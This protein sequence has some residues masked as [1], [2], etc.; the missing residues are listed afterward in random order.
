MWPTP[1]KPTAA[2][3]RRRRE[4]AAVSIVFDCSDAARRRRAV[5][6]P[7]ARCS[8]RARSRPVEVAGDTPG[9][10]VSGSVIDRERIRGR[11]RQVHAP[12]SASAAVR[13]VSP[14]DR[15]T[16]CGREDGGAAAALDAGVPASCPMTATLSGARASR[17]A[18]RV[19]HEH[20]APRRRPRGRSAAP[21]LHVQA[22]RSA[23]GLR[24]VER[25]DAVRRIAVCAGPCRR[26]RPRRSHRRA[27]PRPA[28][29]PH[30]ADGPGMARSV[31]SAALSV[32]AHGGPVRDDDAVEAPLAVE[33]L[34]EQGVFGHR[35]AVDR[36]VGAHDHPRARLTVRSNG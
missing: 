14:V 23:R 26:S 13:R 24:V 28:A 31:P 21:S 16:W 27:P 4:G 11:R 8:E 17:A 25:A 35:G 2:V 6:A 15:R 12:A 3:R 10:P 5:P 7:S 1:A 32:A 33:R 9:P 29:S 18:R 34:V 36:V 19:L 30:G 20:D 22:G